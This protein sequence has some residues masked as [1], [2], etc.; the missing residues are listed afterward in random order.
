MRIVTK[1]AEKEREITKR[2]GM[3]NECECKQKRR[4]ES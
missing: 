1:T 4:R 2:R 3:I